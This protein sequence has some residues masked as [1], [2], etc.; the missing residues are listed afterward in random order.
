MGGHPDTVTEQ[1]SAAIGRRRVDRQHR[2]PLAALTI[3]PDQGADSR[4][5]PRPRR[6]CHTDDTGR[7]N[8]PERVQNLAAPRTFD[9]AQQPAGRPRRTVARRVEEFR[10]IV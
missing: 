1:R 2:D 9:K 3:C 6:P 7:E 8:R 10:N 4:R 5:L